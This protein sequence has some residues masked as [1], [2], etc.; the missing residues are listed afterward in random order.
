MPAIPT[1]IVEL[2]ALHFGEYDE[3]VN[4]KSPEETDKPFISG[5]YCVLTPVLPLPPKSSYKRGQPL[6][7]SVEVIFRDFMHFLKKL[8]TNRLGEQQK[9]S[10]F[11]SS[12]GSFQLLPETIESFLEL[13]EKYEEIN[14]RMVSIGLCL[15]TN[16]KPKDVEYAINKCKFS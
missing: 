10:M 13:N 2:S 8:E 9:E 14:F 12:N 5:Q 7:D 4:I 11:R 3:C 6:D 16:C 1:G 15:P